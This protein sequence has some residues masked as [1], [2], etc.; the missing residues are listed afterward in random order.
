MKM[1]GKR[2]DIGNI[3]S[4]NKANKFYKGIIKNWY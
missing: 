3:D 2:Y 4:Y 1:P